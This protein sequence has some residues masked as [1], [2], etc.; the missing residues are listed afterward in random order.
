MAIT[1]SKTREDIRKA[2]GRN[3]G[4][5]VTGTTSGSG[6]TTTAVDATLFGG[7]DEY[8]GSYIRLTSGTYDGTTRRITDYASSTG[9]MTFS[10][11]A[12]T[13]AGSVTYE[14][15]DSN[16]DPQVIDEFINQ[17]IWE[18]T[19][20][21]YDPEESLDVH[22]DKINARW[23]IPSQF[24]MIQDIYYRHKY[25][26]KTLHACGTTFDETTD[27]DITQAV[28][29]EDYKRDGS[30]LKLTIAAGASAG[31]KITDSISSVDLSK[32]DFIEFW[33]KS[34]VAT[35]AG[36]LKIH[37]DNGTVTADG[38]DLESLNVP[39][40]TADTWKYCR[41]A[42]SNPESDTAIVSIGLEYDSDLGACTVFLDDIKA[43][44]NDTAVWEKL[45]RNT[46]R[47]DKQGSQGASTQ[48]LILNDRGRTL[49]GNNLLKIVGGDEPAELS[50][51]SDTTEVPERFVTAYATALAAQA[52]STR[53]D[54]DMDAMRNI[55]AFWFTKTEQARY[56]LPFLTNVRT[57]R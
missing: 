26:S 34:T 50:A 6:S 38:N 15:W 41:V 33:I 47:I 37:L 20:R 13:V 28:S 23:E 35:S 4:K 17:A 7:D 11:V 55:A 42:L 18:S 40:L 30:S 12:G 43:V 51:D 9:T 25:T 46:W 8:N 29:T 2:I 14:L 39:A 22:T 56:S 54:M 10:A 45:D 49:A 57:V 48:D 5:M 36:N 31:D 52:G 1:Q 3:L 53:T 21:I 44:K 27:S 19:G 24:A 16:F 32:Y